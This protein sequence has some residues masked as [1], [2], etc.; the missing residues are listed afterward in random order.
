MLSSKGTQNKIWGLQILINVD[1]I[2]NTMKGYCELYLGFLGG[3]L[4]DFVCLIV[5]NTVPN[6]NAVALNQKPVVDYS[7]DIAIKLPSN[8]VAKFIGNHMH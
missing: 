6:A 3:P 2:T 4:N 7:L 1:N 5:C 8:L